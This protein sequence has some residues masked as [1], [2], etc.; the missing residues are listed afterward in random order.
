M[1][2][3]P[4]VWDDEV[5]HGTEKRPASVMRAQ[6]RMVGRARLA[7]AL[8]FYFVGAALQFVPIGLLNVLVKHFSGTGYETLTDGTLMAMTA[9]LLVLP[10]CA[11][12]CQTRHDVLM[13][14]YGLQARTAA[15]VAI[16]RHSLRL[17]SA[18]RQG[19]S[20]GEVVNLFSND[21]LK[22]CGVRAREKKFKDKL[23]V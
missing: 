23:G 21:A 1:S 13:V 5:A 16:Y 6:I 22:V 18:A 14:H 9:A 3:S 12:L 2:S 10:V 11:S 19:V 20:T 7:Q 15:A 4:Q 8:G 17:T